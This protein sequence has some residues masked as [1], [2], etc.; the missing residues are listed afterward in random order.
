MKFYKF[1]SNFSMSLALIIVMFGGIELS[2]TTPISAQ[3]LINPGTAGDE[4]RPIKKMVFNYLIQ[5]FKKDRIY[6][7][8][9]AKVNV[10]SL[11]MSGDWL[12]AGYLI[13]SRENPNGW[14]GQ[15]LFKKTEKGWL[16]KGGGNYIQDV[17]T[18]IDF[19]VPPENAQ[20][21]AAGADI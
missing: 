11:I 5:D 15:L 1:A 10:S 8:K 7:G 19:G 12:L 21:L 16:Y 18:L 4:S 17:Q 9:S 13:V 14:A 20:G 2:F 6:L 3:K